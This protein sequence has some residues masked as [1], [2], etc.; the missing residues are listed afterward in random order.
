M[1]T[2]FIRLFK[3]FKPHWRKLLLSQ[4]LL[5]LAV[6]MTVRIAAL[7]GRLVSEGI[8]QGDISAVVNISVL[9]IALAIVQAICTMGNSWLAV[10]FSEGTGHEL[11]VRTFARVQH[12][13]FGDLDRFRTGQLL[14]RMTAD[15]QS[16]KM[17]VLMT[18]MMALQ[19]PI[20]IVLSIVQAAES[21]PQ[22]LYL[23]VIIMLVI[24]S[25]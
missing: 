9:M 10:L 25:R 21:T 6:V 11:R 1:Y 3:S 5:A 17:G 2:S 22:L 23:M 19:A 20:T 15:V 13:S 4:I 24:T 7:N 16:V 14:T 8:E 12:L 18:L